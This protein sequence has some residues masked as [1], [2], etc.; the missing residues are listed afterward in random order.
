[1]ARVRKLAAE[2]KSKWLQMR[3]TLWPDC[4]SAMHDREMA[5]ISSNP[6]KH[7]VLIYQHD[8]AG[9]RLGGF[10]EVSIRDRVDG[11]LSP[12]VGYLEAWYVEPDL[13]GRGIGRQL[14]EA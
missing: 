9:D 10:V 4:S 1:M 5:E 13:R 2:D 3:R 7:G 8:E 11:S 6:D 12:C 14:I